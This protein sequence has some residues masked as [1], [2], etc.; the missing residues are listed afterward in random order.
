[1]TR[2]ELALA[3][4]PACGFVFNSEFDVS[5]LAYGADYDNTQSHSPYFGKYLTELAEHLVQE[6]NVRN[7]RIVEVGCGT[8]A[9]L[10]LLVENSTFGNTGVGFDPSYIGKGPTLAVAYDSSVGYMTKRVPTSWP[11]W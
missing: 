9:F 4:C 3:V 1:M 11:M 10:R 8:G 6:R 7:S 2:G 5:K